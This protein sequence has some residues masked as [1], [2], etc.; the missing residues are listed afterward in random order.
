MLA[1]LLKSILIIQNS[2]TYQKPDKRGRFRL[3]LNHILQG[4][5]FDKVEPLLIDA[6]KTGKARSIVRDDFH[7]AWAWTGMLSHDIDEEEDK[8]PNRTFD[9][10]IDKP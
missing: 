4:I 10:P 9:F 2:G 6:F 3:K 1:N 8:V 7:R 5:V